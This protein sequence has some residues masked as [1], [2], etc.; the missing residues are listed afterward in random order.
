MKEIIE[1]YFCALQNKSPNNYKIVTLFVLAIALILSFLDVSTAPVRFT[2]GV[3]AFSILT[4]L[5][6][7]AQP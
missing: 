3:V 1:K 7:A 4:I 6:V 2:S 5:G